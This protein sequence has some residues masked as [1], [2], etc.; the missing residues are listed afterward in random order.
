MEP[1]PLEITQ[2]FFGQALRAKEGVDE[3][4]L[5]EII[6]C[7][8]AADR[9]FESLEEAYDHVLFRCVARA[10]YEAHP[11]INKFSGLS[12][13]EARARFSKLDREILGLGAKHLGSAL[14]SCTIEEGIGSG[15]KREYTDKS[16]ILNELSKK[17]RH[18][19]L[20]SLLDRASTAIRQ[21]KPCYMMSPYSVAQFLQPAG[22]EFDLL[23]IDEAS[24]MRPEFALGAM[25]RSKQMVVVGDPKQLPPTSFFDRLDDLQEEEEEEDEGVQSESILDLG[26]SVFRP[27]RRLRWHYRSQHESLIA[28]SNMEFY[29][30]RL[31]LFPS[32]YASHPE[33]GV[34]LVEIKGHYK[35]RVNLPEAQRVTA[36]AAN[37]MR[38]YPDQS[39]GIVALNQTQRDL[40]YDE[41]ERISARESWTRDYHA[42][43]DETLEPFFVK[44]LENVQGDERD[45]IFIFDSL[46]P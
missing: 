29:D 24:Q 14:A 41:M 34:S 28:F 44:N 1:Q 19:P 35:G 17:K 39:L 45:V 40:I 20:R 13:E 27:A 46:W 31:I 25:A 7:F 11:E 30:Q 3:P 26:L 4:G 9:P 16:L 6:E 8:E 15:L 2:L 5:R 37:F 42:V 36:A 22:L 38:T 43:W 21:M 32:A 12:Q 33:Y 23:V 18:I 10:I